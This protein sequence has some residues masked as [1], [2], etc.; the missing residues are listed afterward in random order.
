VRSMNEADEEHARGLEAAT[1]RAAGR[2]AFLS[3]LPAAAGKADKAKAVNAVI[4][5]ILARPEHAWSGMSS[6]S[7]L[8]PKSLEGGK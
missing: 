8:P 6:S 4:D 5:E 1:Q 3:T 7:P 2:R